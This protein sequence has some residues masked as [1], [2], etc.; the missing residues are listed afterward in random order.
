MN[1][2]MSTQDQSNIARESGEDR[3]A[4]LMAVKPVEWRRFDRLLRDSL[5]SI[6][7]AEKLANER[8]S[9]LEN[10]TPGEDAEPID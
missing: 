8:H 7:H 9:W 4:T 3:V 10:F 6:R 1:S 2:I 5:F